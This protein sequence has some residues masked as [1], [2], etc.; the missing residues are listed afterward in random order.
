MDTEGEVQHQ[1]GASL[2]IARNE[3][4]RNIKTSGRGTR[5]CS[6]S[7][8]LCRLYLHIFPTL[9]AMFL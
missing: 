1:K 6:A 5:D 8:A 4:S 9:H 7:V 2:N 3:T